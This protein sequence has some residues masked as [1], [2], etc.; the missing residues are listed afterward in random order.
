MQKTAAGI[1]KNARIIPLCNSK[2]ISQSNAP[3]ADITANSAINLK[4]GLPRR[5]LSAKSISAIEL[6]APAPV[7]ERHNNTIN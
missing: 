4:T 1:K 7:A 3:D 6:P 5:I 2:T